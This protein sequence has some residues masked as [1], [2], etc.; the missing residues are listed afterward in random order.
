MPP[1]PRLALPALPRSARL[2]AIFV[3]A[4]ALRC[5]RRTPSGPRTPPCNKVHSLPLPLGMQRRQATRGDEEGEGRQNDASLRR[6]TPFTDE[7]WSRSRGAGAGRGAFA[8][9][10]WC[11]ARAPHKA[12]EMY[13]GYG[14]DFHWYSAALQNAP[15]VCLHAKRAVHPILFRVRYVFHGGQV[16]ETLRYCVHTHAAMRKV[17]SRGRHTVGTRGQ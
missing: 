15:R 11:G 4:N 13:L 12:L 17:I 9:S 2:A 3:N 8:S 1:P 6:P 7:L 16:K 14:T 10:R 5:A